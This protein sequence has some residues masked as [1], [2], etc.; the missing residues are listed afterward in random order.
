MKTTE[1][2][3]NEWYEAN[4]K[5]MEK[6]W[7]EEEISEQYALIEESEKMTTE[8]LISN[9]IS[10]RNALNLRNR[11][12]IEV[13]AGFKVMSIVSEY[14]RKNDGSDDDRSYSNNILNSKSISLEGATK[15]AEIIMNNSELKLKVYK[16]IK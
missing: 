15:F 4:V 13:N 2:I 12:S 16:S 5:G 8:L 9:I 7:S 11:M 1:Q 10:I 6:Y 3:K 14:L